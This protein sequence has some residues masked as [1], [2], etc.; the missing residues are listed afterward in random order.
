MAEQLLDLDSRKARRQVATVRR[1][2]IAGGRS[3]S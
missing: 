1:F 2:T 3:F